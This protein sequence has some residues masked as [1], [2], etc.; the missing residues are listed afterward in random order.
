MAAVTNGHKHGGLKY[1]RFILQLR[2]LVWVYL[3]QNR[4]VS[5]AFLL[6]ALGENP[7]SYFFQL[8][9]VAHNPW[10]MAPFVFRA[11]T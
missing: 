5:E 10:L 8:L 9:E 2:N 6:E 1:H 11:A 7:Y 4:G 3:G